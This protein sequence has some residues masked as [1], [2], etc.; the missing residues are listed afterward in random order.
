[1]WFEKLELVNYSTYTFDHMSQNNFQ[2]SV[3][4]FLEIQYHVI[5]ILDSLR[6]S[7]AYMRRKS[8]HL[9]LR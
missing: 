5:M 8:N 9:S 4:F 6:P 3:E 1:M 7:D 2:Y